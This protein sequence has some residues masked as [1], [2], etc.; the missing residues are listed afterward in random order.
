M[1]KLSMGVE[2]YEGLGQGCIRA[3]VGAR[4]FS[5]GKNGL[6][7]IFDEVPLQHDLKYTPDGL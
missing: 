5:W 1:F 6:Q 7:F 2:C 4:Q 3:A